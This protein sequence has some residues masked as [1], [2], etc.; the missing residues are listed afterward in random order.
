[1]TTKYII[2]NVMNISTLFGLA[3]ILFG[4]S[5]NERKLA[6]GKIIPESELKTMYGGTDSGWFNN[7]YCANDGFQCPIWIGC[8]GGYGNCR[9]C[10]GNLETICID[11]RS[12][13]PDLDGCTDTQH[14]CAYQNQPGW[15]VG[16][17]YGCQ[18]DYGESPAPY[19]ECPLYNICND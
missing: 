18:G 1:M 7:P 14:N 5:S 6:D 8:Y 9:I 11:S 17:V 15:C 10:S 13:W 3:L 12:N 4:C 19:P 16:D 2:V